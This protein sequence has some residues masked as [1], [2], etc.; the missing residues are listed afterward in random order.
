MLRKS[1]HRASA[2]LAAAIGLVLSP[3]VAIARTQQ[4]IDSLIRRVDELQRRGGDFTT[5]S[6][7]EN[8]ERGQSAAIRELVVYNRDVGAS[9][10]LIFTKPKSEEGKGYL[11]LGRNIFFYDPSVGNWSRRTERDRIGGSSARRSDFDAPHFSDDYTAQ[12][13]TD[14]KVGSVST[15]KVELRAKP[16]IEVAYPVIRLWV[17][18][19]TMQTLRAENYSL[20]GKLLRS[21]LFVEWLKTYS[22][23]K[24]ADVWTPKL[25][26]LTSEEDNVETIA[27]TRSVSTQPHAANVF[28]K[29]FIESKSR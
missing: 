19:V 25:M 28:T 29:A 14:E 9:M 21:V 17:D 12:W 20:S 13:L 6:V 24:K 10:T 2:L 22:E 16:G 23:S 4:E 5:V 1:A 7:L 11:I 26:K 18:P 27:V 8:K 3:H 15:V